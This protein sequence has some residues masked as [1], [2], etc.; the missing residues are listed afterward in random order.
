MKGRL[1]CSLIAFVLMPGVVLAGSVHD[2]NAAF[3][4]NEERAKF[5][6]QM[7]CQG[8]HTEDGRGHKSVP[9]LKGFMGH[10]LAHKKGREYLVRVPGSANSV[11]DNEQLTEVLNW[12]LIHFS[13]DSLPEGWQALDIDEVTEYRKDP[14]FEVIEY[15]EQLL[16]VLALK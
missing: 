11:L 13:D 15:R 1:L 3:E 9:N 16:K 10:F 5:N 7:F 4:L 12:M 6:Y 14:L 8:C 2:Q